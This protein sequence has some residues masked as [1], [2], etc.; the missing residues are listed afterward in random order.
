MKL[1][2]IRFVFL[3]AFAV[4]MFK[5]EYA[6][7]DVYNR[8]VTKDVS[9]PQIQ[10]LVLDINTDTI[11]LYT[12]RIINFSFSS[13]NQAI[14]MV[15]FV[16]D[17]SPKF[18]INSSNGIFDLTYGTLDDGQHTLVLEVYTASGTNS[19]ADRVGAERFL[20]SK[21]WIVV[22]DRSYYSRSTATASNGYL[23]LSWPKYRDNDFKEYIVSRVLSYNNEVEIKRLTSTEY[24]DSTYIGEGGAYNIS[25]SKQGTETLD[26]GHIELG[27]ELPGIKLMPTE[28][29]P[30]I[31][32]RGPLKYFNAVDTIKLL[33]NLNYS[34]NWVNIKTTSNP[35]D[36]VY[37]LDSC[38][39]ADYADIMIKYIPKKG[40]IRY[41]P[42]YYDIFEFHSYLT[43]GYPFSMPN[44][45]LYSINQ[46]NQDEFVYLKGC[47]SIVRYSVTLKHQ[48]DHLGYTSLGCSKCEFF[49]ITFSAS[50]KYVTN[51]VNCNP[52]LMLVNTSNMHNYIIQD[53][54]SYTGQYYSPKI[55]ASDVNTAI[56]NKGN[57]GFVIYDF[58]VKASLATYQKTYSGGYGLLISPGGNYLFLVDDSLR[59]VK[60]ENSQFI[61][62]WSHDQFARPKYFG[63]DGINYEQ[64]FIWDGITFSVRRCNDFTEVY[65]FSLFDNM[66]LNI[67]FHHNQLLTYSP[68][69][70]Y[71]RS[72][73]DGSLIKD[74]PIHIDASSFDNSFILVNDAIIS[75]KGV[76]YFNR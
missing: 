68:G 27:R 7:K 62:V 75:K 16:I 32:K 29:E 31:L 72:Y 42:G 59:L 2:G 66:I 25:V 49:N 34:S 55:F 43:I 54:K 40:N 26:W 69:H 50:G 12:D 17:N 9:P 21:S 33:Q 71:I 18:S 52:E 73:T 20:F 61:N 58:N 11:F 70:L 38:R 39:F 22:L 74:L 24:T 5:C 8:A 10:T 1:A 53:L 37:V 76:A 45:N 35:N 65:E 46:I 47:D 23:K 64:M 28:R 13:S 60:F 15:R 3:L 51:Y 19:I 6:P 44:T 41:T 57:G 67:D 63:F 56:V 14:K 30:F 4:L 36:S 48:S